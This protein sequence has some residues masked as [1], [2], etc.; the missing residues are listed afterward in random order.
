LIDPPIEERRAALFN[1]RQAPA[2][3]LPH[4]WRMGDKS[5]KS[6]QRDQKQ[7]DA[8]KVESAAVAKTKQD[9]NVRMQAP[10]SKRVR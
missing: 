2:V 7:K 8:A 9:A 4:D 1:S 10:A 6:K 5:L 3:L